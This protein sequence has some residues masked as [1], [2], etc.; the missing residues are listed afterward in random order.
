[1][2]IERQRAGI[3]SPPFP[4]YP[5]L[6]ECL[7]AGHATPGGGRD[8]TVA[9]VL[10]TCAGYAYGDTET[11]ADLVGRLGLDASACV[12]VAQV[13]DAMLI[14]STAY[15]IQSRCGR[16]VILC[17]RGT[18]LA[19][20]GNW[21]GDADVGSESVT[22]GDDV[23]G[24]HSGFYRNVRA[25]RG[26]VIRELRLAL[27]GRSLAD[28]EERTDHP[29]EALYVTGH[30]LGGAMAVLFSLWVVGIAEHRPI[31]D[32]LRA[33]YTFGQPLTVGEP[34]P[35]VAHAVGSK[36]FRHVIP[37]D[38]IP[39]LPAA[40]WGRLIHLGREYRL[41]SGEWRESETPATQLSNLREIPGSLL[42][43]FAPVKRRHSAR[44]SMA[45]HA[46]HHYI[47]ALRP[48]GRVTEFGDWG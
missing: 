14:Y 35:G 7:R 20:L 3:C 24:V 28:P 37:R 43:F 27:E 40:P 15:V 32:R 42:S 36:L 2:K 22:L 34:L 16:V 47:A 31:A 38:I 12:R 26:P 1:M 25:T 46:P 18:E 39:I 6:V 19:N 17:Y 33:V 13:V 30:S 8:A 11:M 10:G 4:V 48:K 23:L 5:D 29:L 44:Y 45:D 21:L 41:E 9:H